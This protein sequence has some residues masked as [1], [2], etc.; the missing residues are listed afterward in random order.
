MFEELI[1][2]PV[3]RPAFIAKAAPAMILRLPLP[4]V[5]ALAEGLGSE[6]FKYETK[7]NDR[8]HMR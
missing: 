5:G 8:H 2:Y 6:L 3:I 1:P 4:G 7:Q